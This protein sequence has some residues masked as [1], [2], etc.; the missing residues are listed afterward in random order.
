LEID[1]VRLKLYSPA[2]RR[3]A[4]TVRGVVDAYGVVE[5]TKDISEK[6][7]WGLNNAK[8]DPSLRSA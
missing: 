2:N 3:F 8:R 1:V 7:E 5:T 6:S 4:N